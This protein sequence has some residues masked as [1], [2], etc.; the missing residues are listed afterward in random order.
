MK[1]PTQA[2]TPE[3]K[4]VAVKRIKGGQSVSAVCKE[5]GLG[6]QTLRHWI[7]AAEGKLNGTGGRIV[8]PEEMELSRPRAEN[9]KLK[10]EN[11][12]LKNDGV[13]RKGCSVKHAWIDGQGKS[14]SLSEMCGVLDVGIGGYRAWTRGGQPDRQ[15]L[16]DR[17]L[18]ALI[19][20]IH[21]E[22]KNAHGSPRMLRDLRTG[23][24]SASKER[25]ERLMR[26]NQ[27]HARH[28]RRD[29]VRR[30]R[31]MVCRWRRTCLPD[32]SVPGE[33]DQRAASAKTGRMKSSFWQTKNRGNLRTSI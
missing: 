17:R 11:G 27:I 30:T 14:Y 7:K 32:T 20:A 33:L 18:P 2:Y 24:F 3:F 8:T 15:R 16:T 9:L 1:R 23:G 26:E 12:I 29:K 5:R 6:D 19:W 21:A 10:Q 28:K 25:V 22:L 4:E 31:G 13:L